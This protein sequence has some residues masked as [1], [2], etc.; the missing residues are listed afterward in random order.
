[1]LYCVNVSSGVSA[2]HL[3][4]LAKDSTRTGRIPKSPQERFFRSFH[5]VSQ[6]PDGAECCLFAPWCRV[7]RYLTSAYPA[8]NGTAK[9][10]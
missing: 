5:W 2:F 6:L 1:M 8:R 4:S 10:A 3:S 9:L 7:R